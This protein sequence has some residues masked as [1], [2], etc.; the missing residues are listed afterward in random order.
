MH[1]SI[2]VAWFAEVVYWVFTG[3][4]SYVF[5]RSRRWRKISI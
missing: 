2:E 1:T 3:I 4:V 5:I